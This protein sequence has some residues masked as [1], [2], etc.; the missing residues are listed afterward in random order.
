MRVLTWRTRLRT[1]WARRLAR[2]VGLQRP[3]ARF[4]DSDVPFEFD[5]AE[6]KM[7]KSTGRRGVHR[8]CARIELLLEQPA[9]DTD[10][11]HWQARREGV[12][13]IPVGPWTT[14]ATSA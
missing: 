13:A 5:S 14:R 3:A 11:G 6:P 9:L 8:A 12:Q 2:G 1:K 10:G 7:P 4:I